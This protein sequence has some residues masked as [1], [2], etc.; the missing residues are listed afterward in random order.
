MIKRFSIL[1]LFIVLFLFICES[2][3]NDIYGQLVVGTN[4]G[5]V[6]T[7][8]IADP[9]EGTTDIIDDYSVGTKD[10]SPATA[11]RITE[12][13]WWCDNATEAANFEVGIYTHD[14]G[15]NEPE[16]VVGSLSTVNAKGTTAGWK[17]VTG[18][19]IEISSSTT[20]W[21]CV[22]LDNVGTQTN[23]EIDETSTLTRIQDIT[24]TELPD[25]TWDIGG[26]V[27]VNEA[28][29]IYA[30]WDEGELTGILPKVSE[31]TIQPKVDAGTIIPKVRSP[32]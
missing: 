20:Y 8:P 15:N 1:V 13:G 5:F 14:A 25:P 6:I 2:I 16:T 21:I 30:V 27:D 3:G 24:H 19:S 28:Y 18:L 31:G 17:R 23:I 26:T 32:E 11:G 7:A 4:C 22:Q 29:G 10:S 12:I 9:A